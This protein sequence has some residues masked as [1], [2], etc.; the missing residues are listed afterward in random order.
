[1]RSKFQLDFDAD[2]KLEDDQ[3]AEID[4]EIFP[5]LVEENQIPNINFRVEGEDDVGISIASSPGPQFF[6]CESIS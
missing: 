4:E 2:I 6:Y 3:G 5:A 1:M